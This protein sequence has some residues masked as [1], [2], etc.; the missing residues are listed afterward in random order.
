MRNFNVIRKISI[1]LPAVFL[2]LTNLQ[3]S[4][5]ENED[6]PRSAELL[7]RYIRHESITGN[8][9]RAGI[10]LKNT[11]RQKDLHV[12]VLTDEQDS[13]N[14]TASLYPLDSGKPNII[15]LNHIDVVP[16]GDESAW[17]HPPFS[18]RIAD[19]YVWGRGAI[20]NKGMAVMQLL[21]LGEFAEK[22]K[23]EDFPVNITMLSVSGEETG[24]HTG[25]RIITD[26]FMELLNP[27]ALYGEGGS[28]LPGVVKGDPDRKIM[29]ISVAHKRS[30]WLEV[31]L[32][33]D[34][35]G[36][37]AV[38]PET[39]AIKE[40]VEA[41]DNLFNRRI[42]THFSET[43]KKM[44]SEVGEMEKGIRGF[45][46]RNVGFFRPFLVPALRGDDVAL[47]TISNTITVTGINTPDL[48]PNQI[49][50]S[51]TA[52]LDCRLLPGFAT[53][54]FISKI[55]GVM[56]NDRI[57]VDIIQE[58]VAADPSPLNEYYGLLKDALEEVFE[59]SGVVPILV[60]AAN[61]N[62]FF[63]AEGVP[64]YGAPPVYLEEELIRSIHN[65]N[66]RMPVDMLE[67]GVDVYNALI[68]KFLEG[69]AVLN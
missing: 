11:A 53:D 28:G 25:A 66:E 26:E 44:F 48:P 18:G 38:P 23:E 6:V 24:G 47:S 5:N 40:K 55:R 65:V 34:I 62:N 41:L 67:K 30:L 21:A 59:G 36:H 51:V 8:E 63:R 14:F 45:A 10:F 2:F 16:A 46:L 42:R 15:L 57:S 9:R 7:S 49:A 64:S 13:Y 37:G 35:S 3:A 31:T 43:T 50:P 29:G 39:Y 22:A 27:V 1:L 17:K 61:D 60:P 52:V 68:E 20:D 12:E 32:D 56:E 33:T 58:G 4:G 54:D 69:E 19:G